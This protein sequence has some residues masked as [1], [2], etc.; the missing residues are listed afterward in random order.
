[1]SASG[2]QGPADAGQAV[3]VTLETRRRVDAPAELQGTGTAVA[4]HM[5]RVDVR[6]P[7]EGVGDLPQAVAGAVDQH[8]PDVRVGDAGQ[9]RLVVANR[10]VHEHDFMP[11][12]CRIAQALQERS[13]LGQGGKEGR[14]SSLHSPDD[15]GLR[16]RRMDR[17]IRSHAR[18]GSALSRWALRGRLGL[19]RAGLRCRS[20][21]AE[22]LGDDTSS[23]GVPRKRGD[24]R[25]R[26]DRDGGG[27]GG[28]AERILQRTTS[29]GGAPASEGVCLAP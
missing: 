24:G 29:Q 18:N 13:L 12:L 19:I 20:A 16:R 22:L 27:A 2:A 11:C 28:L 17:L 6:L 8:H 5:D 25:V 10:G 1:M 4:D 21:T 9:Q 3:L 23:R 26:A 14:R 15:A 7:G